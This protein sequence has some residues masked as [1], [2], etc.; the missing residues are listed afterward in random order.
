MPGKA[1]AVFYM[2]CIARPFLQDHDFNFDASR[3]R[4]FTYNVIY[5]NSMAA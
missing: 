3:N 4:V 1:F 5:T 2:T